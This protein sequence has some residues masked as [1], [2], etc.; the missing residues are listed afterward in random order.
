MACWGEDKENYTGR[1]KPPGR[2]SRSAGTDGPE[3]HWKEP[4]LP[5]ADDG[6]RRTNQPVRL[7]CAPCIQSLPSGA[8]P[9][10]IILELL[11]SIGEL[12][13]LIVNFR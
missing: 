1:K 4:P 10:Q 12:V 11:F 3:F 7:S 5:S 2:N 13:P 9:W 6:E 8:I